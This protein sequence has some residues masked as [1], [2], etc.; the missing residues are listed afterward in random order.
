M[1]AIYKQLVEKSLA[2]ALAAIEIYN[3][4]DFRYREESFVILLVNAWELLAKAKILKDAR[5]RMSSLYIHDGKNNRRIKRSRTGNPLTIELLG[6]LRKLPV[7]DVVIENLS[8]LIDIRDTAVH[9][10]NDD[11]VRYIV[12]TL[13]VAA[14]RNYQALSK[15]WFKRSLTAY[16]FYI[17]PI[18]FS[19]AFRT[20]RLLDLQTSP[21]VV[22]T[23][24]KAVADAQERSKTENGYYFACEIGTE[25]RS[26]KK[27]ADSADLT[28]KIDP[29]APEPTIVITQTKKKLD[30]YP[31]SYTELV[32][33]VKR[34]VPNLRASA[35]PK[36][37]KRHK[38]KD[39]ESYAAYSFRTK[40]QEDTF[41]R[42]KQLPKGI[43]SIYN[44]DAVRFVVQKA[45]EMNATESRE[46][47]A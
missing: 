43:T 30:L 12:Y 8:A 25:L 35:I 31:L 37:I 38:V 19:H 18:G 28:V 40:A 32:Q 24:L 13:G 34:Q 22:A 5:N 17:L 46:V 45:D 14:L 1:K 11:G 29:N 6:A 7:D 15:D 16:H 39:N 4:P 2:A 10:Y 44:E 27:F 3:K 23:L 21:P 36:I 41:L 42:T 26:A 33:R 9:F 47:R 20:F